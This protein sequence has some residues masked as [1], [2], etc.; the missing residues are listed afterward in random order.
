MTIRDNTGPFIRLNAIRPSN[1]YQDLIRIIDEHYS[2][3]ESV[4]KIVGPYIQR[5]FQKF[6]PIPD[7]MITNAISK[8]HTSEIH[9]IAF[10]NHVLDYLNRNKGTRTLYT[11]SYITHHSAQ[12]CQNTFMVQKSD[13]KIKGMISPYMINMYGTKEP[14]YVDFG[15]RSVGDFKF[16]ILRPKI[17]KTVV[18]NV[19]SW[20]VMLYYKN[21][22]YI[23]DHIDVDVNPSYFS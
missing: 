14:I 21:I 7:E 22:G 9:K 13:I 2:E 3:Y 15:K 12:F 23:P 20:E 17:G 10:K 19:S 5:N 4:A 18:A 6:T 16:M 11:P 1:D 8:Y